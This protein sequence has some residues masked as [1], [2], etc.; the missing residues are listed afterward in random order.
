MLDDCTHLHSGC[1]GNRSLL[2]VV[3]LLLLF[4]Y[5]TSP[6]LTSQWGPTRHLVNP[7]VRVS[8]RPLN[9]NFTSVLQRQSFLKTSLSPSLVTIKISTSGQI[10]EFLS[11]PRETFLWCPHSTVTTEHRLLVLD[12]TTPT[13]TRPL[14]PS[15]SRLVSTSLCS[16]RDDRYSRKR[17]EGSETF[18]M[19]F[20]CTRLAYYYTENNTFSRFV[21]SK[22]R[23]VTH[24]VSDTWTLSPGPSPWDSWISAF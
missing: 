9:L 20:V 15:L 1:G 18:L 24:F 14:Y 21:G 23:G 19:V 4:L 10:S 7:P 11:S 8:G 13:F 22:V 2:C 16:F 3:L 6:L 17:T 12:K 5:K